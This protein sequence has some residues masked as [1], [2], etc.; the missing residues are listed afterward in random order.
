MKSILDCFHLFFLPRYL[1]L[2][3]W[4][5]RLIV[6]L[7]VFYF[8]KCQLPVRETRVLKKISTALTTVFLFNLHAIQHLHV[9]QQHR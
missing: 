5:H 9:A 6:V 3:F 7:F 4:F 8:K 2:Y 1:V